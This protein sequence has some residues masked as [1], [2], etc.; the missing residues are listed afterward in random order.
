M[1][2]SAAFWDRI[3]ERYAAKPV[4]DEAA[5]QK[6]L[7]ITREYLRPG[8][9]M[10]EFGCGT[11]ST[12]ISHAPFV[13]HI[14]AIDISANMIDIAQRKAEAAGI[15]NI[16]FAVSSIEEFDAADESYDVVL[17]LS[18]LHLVE[19]KEAII[20][21]VHGMLKPGGIFV[22]STACIGDAQRF[23]KLMFPLGRLLGLIPL[24]KVFTTGDLVKAMT[25]G[26]FTIEHQWSPGKNK[27]VFLV[28]VKA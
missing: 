28:A 3:A 13:S 15:D 27:A 17:G 23:L 12:A 21:R 20:A 6:K 25:D 26:G 24:V 7:A 9:K 19:N 10:F 1:T 8:M 11:G 4:A 22:T 16:S 5:Y 2:P 14:D 18:I